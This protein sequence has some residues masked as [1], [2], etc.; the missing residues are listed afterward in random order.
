MPITLSDDEAYQM[1]IFMDTL[2]RTYK[3]E[4]QT[5]NRLREVVLPAYRDWHAANPH[6]VHPTSLSNGQ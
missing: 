2:A 6:K 4:H 1:F 3:G 5:V